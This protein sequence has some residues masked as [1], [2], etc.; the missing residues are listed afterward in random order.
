[1]CKNTLLEEAYRL[2]V[3]EY[4]DFP[5]QLNDIMLWE[6]P[7]GAYSSVYQNA[8]RIL[9]LEV[10]STTVQLEQYA[11]QLRAELLK[12]SKKAIIIIRES[13]LEP[14]DESLRIVLHELTHAYC[15]SMSKNMPPNDEVMRFLFQIGE[16][17][18]KEYTAEYLVTKI[19]LL[20]ENWSQS[21]IEREFKSLL[22]NL[23]FYPERLGFFFIKCKI[24]ATSSIQVAEAVGIKD[25]TGATKKL[26]AVMSKMQNILEKELNQSTMLEVSNEFL[27]QLGLEIVTFVYYY[28]Q[29]YNHIETFLKQT[30]G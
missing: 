22:Y 11:V 26:I 6:A 9:R 20:E 19:F 23:S 17:M 21:S 24:T 1:M 12:T 5:Y 28:F 13:L 10:K 4:P 16:R 18:W 15:D 2:F 29:C 27:I 25:E 7:E 14:S 30:E 3:K 8:A